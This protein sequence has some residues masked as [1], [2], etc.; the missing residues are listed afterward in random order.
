MTNFLLI[1]SIL[2]LIIGHTLM[3]TLGPK[4]GPSGGLDSIGN[5]LF[6]VMAWRFCV[7][8]PPIVFAVIGVMLFIK[9]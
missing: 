8:V 5:A 7:W 4:L 1:A 3:W 6:Y 2:W 9:C